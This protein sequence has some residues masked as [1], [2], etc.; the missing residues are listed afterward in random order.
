MSQARARREKSR[1]IAAETPKRFREFR[2][3]V[4]GEIR[5][6]VKNKLHIAI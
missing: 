2:I 5:T 6:R 1:S 3:A 4:G